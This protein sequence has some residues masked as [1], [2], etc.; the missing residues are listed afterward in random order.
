MRIGLVVQGEQWDKN[1]PDYTWTLFEGATQISHTITR[2]NGNYRYRTYETT[3]PLRNPLWN[4]V[5]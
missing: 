2:S 3:I 5:S 1:A 4:P